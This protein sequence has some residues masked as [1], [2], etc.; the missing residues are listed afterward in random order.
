MNTFL[1]QTSSAL[2]GGLTQ[3]DNF[4]ALVET[5]QVAVGQTYPM[6]VNI[7]SLRSRPVAVE[8]GKFRAL[9]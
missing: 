6:K 9:V 5:L 4:R 8:V 7:A 1:E 2:S 3:A